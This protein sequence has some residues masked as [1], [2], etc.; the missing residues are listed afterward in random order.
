MNETIELLDF[1]KRVVEDAAANFFSRSRHYLS[2]VSGIELGGREV[3]LVADAVLE[4]SLLKKL[5]PTGLSI[6]SEE[7]GLIRQSAD[8]ELLWVIDPLDGSVNYLR[9]IGPSAVSVAL[10]RGNSPVFGVLYRLDNKSLSW[11]GREVGAWSNGEAIR[12][13]GESRIDRAII[14]TGIP[15]RFR[16]KDPVQVDKYFRLIAQF[17]KVRMIGSAA[18]SLLMVARGA[19]DAY[20]ED[21][22]ML[23]DVA[24]GLAIIEGAGGAYWTLAGESEFSCR[25]VAASLN[26]Q[27][28]LKERGFI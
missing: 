24:A 15:A 18:S 2:Q 3:K 8:G 1:T 23:W 4:E 12:V 19:A 26:L 20:F 25:V 11:G 28:D 13:S 14:C 7:T 10:Y 16:A 6:L 22:I 9:G 27:S 21:Q 5:R 17:A